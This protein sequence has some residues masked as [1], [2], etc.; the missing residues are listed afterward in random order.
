MG[1]RNATGV[2]RTS[3]EATADV[4][5]GAISVA[6][7]LDMMLPGIKQGNTSSISALLNTVQIQVS[8][9][10]LQIIAR[11]LDTHFRAV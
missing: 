7:L 1:T 9:S 2:A 10:E 8:R 5:C 4:S 11:M 6:T 3:W